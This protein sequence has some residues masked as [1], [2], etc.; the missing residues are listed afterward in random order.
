MG[1]APYYDTPLTFESYTESIDAIGGVNKSWTSVVAVLGSRRER[2]GTE[3][4]DMGNINTSYI[5]F[6]IRYYPGLTDN[7]RVKY[8]DV[9]YKIT[10]ITMKGRYDTLDVT[11]ERLK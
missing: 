11:L 9:Y 3:G 2:T 10:S 7:M 8:N 4:Y 1:I 6:T 5:T